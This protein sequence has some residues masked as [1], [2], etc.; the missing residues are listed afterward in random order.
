MTHKELTALIGTVQNGVEIIERIRNDKGKYM[1]RV[2]YNG[3]EFLKYRATVAN[4]IAGTSRK[5]TVMPKSQR[6]EVTAS[7]SGNV[8]T[9]KY[10][11]KGLSWGDVQQ[12]AYNKIDSLRAQARRIEREIDL[13]LTLSSDSS[14]LQEQ[15]I[16]QKQ[17]EEQAA[18]KKAEQEAKQAEAQRRADRAAI[19]QRY[20]DTYDSKIVSTM[21]QD[22]QKGQ[23]MLLQKQERI[24]RAQAIIAELGK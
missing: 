12:L 17:A 13:L 6:A 2:R 22:M 14:F 15:E 20:I 5:S 8:I 9:Y 4:M 16:L 1:Y 23:I 11:T 19:L 7:N 18:L 21:L 10:N 3:Q 24:N